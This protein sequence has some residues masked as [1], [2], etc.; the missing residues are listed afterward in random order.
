MNPWLKVQPSRIAKI[1][2]E[3]ADKTAQ[4]IGT[5]MMALNAN[6]PHPLQSLLLAF[7]ASVKRVTA[8]SPPAIAMIAPETAI[9]H[10]EVNASIVWPPVVTVTAFVSGLPRPHTVLEIYRNPTHGDQPS[11]AAKMRP[12][13]KLAKHTAAGQYRSIKLKNTF[14]GNLRSIGPEGESCRGTACT[15][16][17]WPE[18]KR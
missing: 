8:D 10:I 2:P 6:T 3:L 13:T 16:G 12:K 5:P 7:T 9:P 17:I 1:A 11:T 4:T 14:L 15:A 18:L